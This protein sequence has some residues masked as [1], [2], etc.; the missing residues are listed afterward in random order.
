MFRSR[1][2]ASVSTAALVA[3]GIAFAAPA[4][5]EPEPIT[6]TKERTGANPIVAGS[7]SGTR[8]HDHGDEQPRGAVFDRR[9]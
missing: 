8:F 2:F 6:I 5:A 4:S 3:S 7:S 1:L 9:Q